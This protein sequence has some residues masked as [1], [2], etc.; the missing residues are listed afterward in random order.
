MSVKAALRWSRFYEAEPWGNKEAGIR[1]GML[2]ISGGNLGREVKAEE[3][4][5]AAPTREQQRSAERFER[6]LAEFNA[7]R[8]SP[9][10][11]K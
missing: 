3:F 8:R 7:W 10:R 1:T 5:V 11:E 4:I 2:A 6:E 9:P